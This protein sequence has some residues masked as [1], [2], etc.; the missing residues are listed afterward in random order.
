M[1]TTLVRPQNKVIS[2]LDSLEIG[3]IRNTLG[4]IAQFQS[5]IQ[6]TFKNEDMIMEKLEEL[7]SQPYLSQVR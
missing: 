3:E 4:K 1:E 2:L 6:K 7:Q 5:I